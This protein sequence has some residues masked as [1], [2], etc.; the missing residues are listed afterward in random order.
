MTTDDLQSRLEKAVLARSILINSGHLTAF[1]LFSGFYEGYPDLTADVYARTMVLYDYA[2]PP[3][4]RILDRAQDFLLARLP[5]LDSALQ[6]TRSSPDPLRRRGRLTYGEKPAFQVQEHGVQY[7]L[8]LTLNQD[9]S[10]YLDTRGLRTWLLE[11]SS[12]LSIINLFAYTGALGIAALA[13]GADQVVQVDRSDKFL[14]LAGASCSL[15]HLDPGKMK[16]L[17]MDFFSACARFKRSGDLFDIAI[18]DPPYISTTKK[19]VV[20][21]ANAYNRLVNKVRPLVKDGGFL[22]AINNALFLKGTDYLSSLELLGR[23]GYLSIET[24]LPV[25]DDITGYPDARITLPPVDPSPFNHPT[26]IA[27]L[28]VRRKG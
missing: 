11:R 13:G 16:L 28:K 24:I 23:D 6:K 15:N 9:A 14:S 1:R 27:I 3:D 20:D 25:P 8:D 22:V 19:G 12:G 18:M 5:W 17:A 7:A 26:K 2:D 10:F 21:L 4:H